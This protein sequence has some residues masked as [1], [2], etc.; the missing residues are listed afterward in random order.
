[1]RKVNFVSIDFVEEPYEYTP[2]GIVCAYENA[3]GDICLQ[4]GCWLYTSDNITRCY[5]RCDKHRGKIAVD[6]GDSVC[7]KVWQ[8]PEADEDDDPDVGTP[9]GIPWSCSKCGYLSAEC[10]CS[11]KKY[12]NG[13]LRW[14]LLPLGP[15]EEV[16]EILTYGAEKYGPNNWQMVEDWRDRYF[17]A[18]MRH[19]IAWRKGERDDK[20]SGL[21]HLAHALC[22]L[23][24]LRYLECDKDE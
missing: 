21:P 20:E 1:M 16:V 9:N 24:F 14:D 11:G 12:D 3:A 18:L 10:V 4:P 23:T 7:I 2:G 6:V 15:V 22:N 5:C 17:A 13:K 19:L 8:A